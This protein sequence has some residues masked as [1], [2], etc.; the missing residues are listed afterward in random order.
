M[1]YGTS[2]RPKSKFWIFARWFFLPSY[3]RSPTP[4]AFRRLL[5]YLARVK[6]KE[7]SKKRQRSAKIDNYVNDHEKFLNPPPLFFLQR[8]PCFC[9]PFTSRKSY[10]LNFQTQMTNADYARMNW[11]LKE[12]EI[13]RFIHSIHHHVG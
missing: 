7:R 12:C 4:R 6:P 8:Y 1:H 9:L 10:G 13:K 5:I 2:T 3:A 11:S